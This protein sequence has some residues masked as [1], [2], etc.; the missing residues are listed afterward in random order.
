MKEVDRRGLESVKLDVLVGRAGQAVAVAALDLLGGAY[1]RRIV[2]IAGRGNNGAD[3]RVA[4]GVLARR[5]ARVNVVAP[6]DAGV[7]GVERRAVD[8]VV[9]AAYGTGFHGGY[10]A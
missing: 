3:G 8:L 5:G 6:G 1:G 7:V 2:V 4:A 9:D 10:D